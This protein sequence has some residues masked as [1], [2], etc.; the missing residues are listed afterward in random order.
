MIHTLVNFIQTTIF[1][2]GWFGVFLAEFIEEI[3]VPIPSAVIL[4]G[5]G[6]VFL[7]G[8]IL[9]LV[10]VKNL[11][12]TVVIP[13]SLGLTL[14][15]L[16]IYKLSF[17]FENIF[18][19]KFGKILSVSQGDI[20]KLNERFESGKFDEIFI[21]LAR[22]FPLI[23]S[24]L[25]AVFC[26]LIKMPF[27]KYLTLTFIGAFF[28]SLLLAMLGFILGDIYYKYADF[29]SK[30]ENTIF[31]LVIVFVLMFIIYRKFYKKVI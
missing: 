3:I 19:S 6:F 28:R 5:S 4:L 11:F 22:V 20:D 29:I 27:K 13:A 2:W 8:D 15:S 26:G 23:P 9:T 17:I 31:Y 1:P 24:V 16:V 21:V 10:F 14:G 25:L 12:L 7:K 30:I 18:L